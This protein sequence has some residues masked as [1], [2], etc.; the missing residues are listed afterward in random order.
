MA[1]V[2]NFQGWKQMIEAISSENN[3]SSR[4]KSSNQKKIKLDLEKLNHQICSGLE[5]TSPSFTTQFN[6]L[7]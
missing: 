5:N 7:S 1:R 2:F 4:Q 6:L 3:S